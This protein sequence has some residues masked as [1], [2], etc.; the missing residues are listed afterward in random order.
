MFRTIVNEKCLDADYVEVLMNDGYV[1][2][3]RDVKDALIEFHTNIEGYCK[4]MDKDG[5][6]D[7]LYKFI[8]SLQLDV[9]TYSNDILDHKLFETMGFIRS[10]SSPKKEEKKA[11][12]Q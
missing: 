9:N 5:I 8:K 11:A 2:G 6:L 3:L 10:L 1:Q 4:D 12:A 7:A